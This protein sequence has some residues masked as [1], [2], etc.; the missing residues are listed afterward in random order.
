MLLLGGD[1][2]NE[3]LSQMIYAKKKE[4]IAKVHSRSITQIDKGRKQG[5]WKTYVGNP[6]KEVVR[7]TERELID[8][9]FHYYKIEEK[10]NRSFYSVFDERMDYLL[11]RKNR[12]AKTVQKYQRIYNKFIPKN[13][14]AQRIADITEDDVLDLIAEKCHSIHPK[15]D[16]LKKFIQMVSATFEFGV[17]NGYCPS[18][19]ASHVDPEC[20]Y[21]DC[22][23]KVKQAD[24]KEFSEEERRILTDDAMSNAGNPRALML[25]MA[26]ETGMRAG[27]LAAFH[28]EDILEK[29]TQGLL[30]IHRQQLYDKDQPVG[31]QYWEVAYTKDERMHPHNGR[32]FP[33]NDRIREIIH[34]TEKIPGKSDYLFHDAYQSGPVTK[35]SHEKYL[36]RRCRILGIP[37]T[38]NHAFRMALNSRLI[39][40][41]LSA[42]ER[43]VLLGHAV[44][45]NEQHYSLADQ[46]LIGSITEKL[47]LHAASCAALTQKSA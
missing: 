35:G 41:G 47:T 37:T 1:A 27:E 33:I 44:Q 34:L 7:Q 40:A 21:K 2:D 3:L 18:N 14:G 31:K 20:Y 30:H 39:E 23:L 26:A 4:Y 6:R 5:M 43:A 22:D 32:K 19:P 15:P 10:L 11:T 36:K 16:A 8:Y 25:M 17:Q 29:G 13:L 28:K 12:S 24:E 42:A 46:R 45:T 38:N 9:L